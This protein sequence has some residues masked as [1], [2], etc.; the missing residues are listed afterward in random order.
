MAQLILMLTPL[1]IMLLMQDLWIYEFTVNMS[2]S[3]M[4]IENSSTF[5]LS[6]SHIYM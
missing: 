1:L 4:K 3:G 5:P 6:P 2:N